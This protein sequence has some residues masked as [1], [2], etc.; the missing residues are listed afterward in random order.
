M[1]KGANTML[2]TLTIR[3]IMGWWLESGLVC[4]SILAKIFALSVIL[5]CAWLILRLCDSF[6][7][8]DDVGRSGSVMDSSSFNEQSEHG[9]EIA[10]VWH[11]VAVFDSTFISILNE[12]FHEY[13]AKHNLGVNNNNESIAAPEH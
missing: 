2:N 4:G 3:Y 8:K 7:C 12:T 1:A 9:E 10:A 6:Q 11:P 13:G 5:T